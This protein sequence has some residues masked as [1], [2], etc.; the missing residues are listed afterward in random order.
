MESERETVLGEVLSD[1]IKICRRYLMIFLIGAIVVPLV[2]GGIEVHAGGLFWLGVKL[3]LVGWLYVAF[4][5]YSLAMFNASR[6][7]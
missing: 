4:A 3:G 1:T 2:C 6:V 5:V 7:Y